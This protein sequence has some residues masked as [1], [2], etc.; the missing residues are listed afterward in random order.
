MTDQNPTGGGN[1]PGASGQASVT[2]T[3][4]PAP[5]APDQS[6]GEDQRTFTQA[7][8]NSF[9]AEERRKREEAEAA[10]KAATDEL[11]KLKT[12]Q[13][14]EQEQAIEAAKSATREEVSKEFES[15][16]LAT[17]LRARLASKGYPMDWADNVVSHA[18]PTSTADLDGAIEKCAAELDWFKPPAGPPG[19]IQPGG[20]SA[21][22]GKPVYTRANFEDVKF[23]S[24]HSADMDLAVREGRVRG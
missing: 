9:N 7:Q 22:P 3:P 14:T 11:T 18:K 24:E 2:P 16:V 10:H 8:V 4:T 21:Q 20:P 6:T 17:D 1:Q 12:A 5:V 23:Y 15:K 13:M 19:E